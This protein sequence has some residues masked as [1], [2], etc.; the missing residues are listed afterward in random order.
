MLFLYDYGDEQ[1][2]IIMVKRFV[3][4]DYDVEYPELVESVGEAPL[5]NEAGNG[6]FQQAFSTLRELD[7]KLSESTLNLRNA[8]D[9]LS[10]STKL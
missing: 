8:L 3:T 7:T 10:S 4:Y 2:F 5:Q 1:H 9:V 6:E